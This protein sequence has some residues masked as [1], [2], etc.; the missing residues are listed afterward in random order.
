MKPF[1]FACFMFLASTRSA[2]P[3]AG[4]A[5]GIWRVVNP[6]S[7]GRAVR[8]SK[9]A[10]DLRPRVWAGVRHTCFPLQTEICPVLISDPLF[11]CD[12]G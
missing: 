3:R 7:E 8:H 4:K 10:T 1:I 6:S 9:P 12:L 2:P 5:T 11:V